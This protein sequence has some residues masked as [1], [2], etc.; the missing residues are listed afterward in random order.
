ML[1]LYCFSLTFVQVSYSQE[2][3][4]QESIPKAQNQDVSSELNK[5]K[6]QLQEVRRDQLNYK[7]EKDLLKETYSSNIQTV[8]IIIAIVLA[9]FAILGYL[10]LKSVWEMK[11]EYQK[12]LNDLRDLKEK[13]NHKFL[14]IESQQKSAEK[15]FKEIAEINE[16]QDQRLS[17]LEI[18][19]KISTLIRNG[20]F[21]RAYSQVLQGLEQYPDDSLLRSQHYYS[22]LKLKR[23]WEAF[24]FAKKYFEED[25]NNIYMLADFIEIAIL[26]ENAID[27]EGLMSKYRTQLAEYYS[28]DLI[29]YFDTL[30][31]YFEGDIIKLVDQIKS[32]VESQNMNESSLRING[33][34]YDEAR[35]FLKGKK[36]DELKTIMYKFF[37]YLDGDINGQELLNIMNNTS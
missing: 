29:F 34:M 10:G 25:E 6:E 22:L 16:K 32:Y 15:K 35:E 5:I 24:D 18:Q 27:Y 3:Q 37:E 2:Q 9:F 1:L 13:F 19:E 21:P 31:L 36:D 7:I 33:W 14:E 28:E 11:R 12:E 8:N 4:I 20:N 23:F 26:L 30:R 17:L